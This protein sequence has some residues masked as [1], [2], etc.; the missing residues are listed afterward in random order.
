[1]NNIELISI[2]ENN[3]PN[4]FQYIQNFYYEKFINTNEINKTWLFKGHSNSEWK[5]QSMIERSFDNYNLK[6]DKYFN[7]EQKIIREFKRKA[8]NLLR[9]VPDEENIFEWLS[10]MRHYGAPCRLLDFTYSF[11]VALFFAIEQMIFKDST[12][13]SECSI[14]ALNLKLFDLEDNVFSKKYKIKSEIKKNLITANKNSDKI[15][16]SFIF[17]EK[18]DN[19]FVFHITPY[20]LNERVIIQQGTFLI[21]WNINKNF[22]DNLEKNREIRNDKKFIKKIK[23]RMN[24][25]ERKEI[26]HGLHRMNINLSTLYPDIE[27]F[28]KS[29]GIRMEVDK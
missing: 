5:L 20:L 24:K 2:P 1:M 7:T 13:S 23:I 11:F 22:E 26:I 8:H 28:S 27:G 3:Y 10:L 16:D 25:D 17:N 18:N 29:L 19:S 6:A 12:S 14:Y 15:I 9:Q 4:F 21:P